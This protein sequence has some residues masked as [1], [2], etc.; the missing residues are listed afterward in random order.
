MPEYIDVNLLF[1]CNTCRNYVNRKCTTFCDWGE[2]YSPA[3]SKL[4]IADVVEVV[5][6]KDCQ[7]YIKEYHRCSLHSEEPDQYSTGFIFEMQEDDF[8]SCGERKTE[9]TDD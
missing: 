4:P 2:S 8:C 7:H 3:I 1:K 5:R 9:D 6:C